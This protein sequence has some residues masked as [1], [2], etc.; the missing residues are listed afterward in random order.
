MLIQV[1]N[2]SKYNYLNGK[3]ITQ[4]NTKQTC[5]KVFNT[6]F[7][8]GNLEARPIYRRTKLLN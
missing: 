2:I 1:H 6:S 3:I 4:A 7:N 8:E 5:A